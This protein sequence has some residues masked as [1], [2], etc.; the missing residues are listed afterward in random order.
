MSFFLAN[1]A[2][3]RKRELAGVCALFYTEACN[4]RF[5][6]AFCWQGFTG[7]VFEI[8]R[9]GPDSSLGRYFERI[10]RSSERNVA[11]DAVEKE[12]VEEIEEIAKNGVIDRLVADEKLLTIYKSRGYRIQ[13]GDNSVLMVKKLSDDELDEVYGTSFYIGML[14]WF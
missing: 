10:G 7:G 8:F 2:Q 9:R 6:A 1:E 4:H 3:L 14:D 12:L 13:K 5:C 11:A